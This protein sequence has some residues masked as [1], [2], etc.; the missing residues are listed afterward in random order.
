MTLTT[1]LSGT[2]VAHRLGHAVVNLPTKL[3]VPIFT[4]YGN[5]TGVAKC[6]RWGGLG[7]HRS[8]KVIENSAIR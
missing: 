6:R 4:R 3:E 2:F 7:G 1:P 5:M 8:P